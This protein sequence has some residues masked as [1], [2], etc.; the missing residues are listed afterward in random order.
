MVITHHDD[1]AV[2]AVL[3]LLIMV[4]SK[5]MITHIIHIIHITDITHI[6]DIRLKESSCES[7]RW[8]QSLLTATSPQS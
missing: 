7:P 3:T 2:N 8:Q 5:M 1:V 4:Q 6:T